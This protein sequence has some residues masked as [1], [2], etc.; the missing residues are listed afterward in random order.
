MGFRDM[1][2]W[3]HSFFKGL[4][5]LFGTPHRIQ[6]TVFI[7]E[8]GIVSSNNTALKTAFLISEKDEM[9]WEMEQPL[10]FSME[11]TEE[12]VLLISER[13]YK[14][15][16]PLSIRTAKDENKTLT[17][18]GDEYWD[19]A[20]AHRVKENLK[21]VNAKMVTT[22]LTLTFILTAIIVTIALLRR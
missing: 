1:N 11:G 18:I 22:I 19:K 20:K 17:N 5:T 8:S 14:P 2:I 16:D 13:T 7:S 9:A 4:Q 10:Q 21:S 12:F 15:L 3:K 6:K